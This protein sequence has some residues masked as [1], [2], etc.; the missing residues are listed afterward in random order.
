MGI[1]AA[2]IDRSDIV[3]KML[4]H[5]L[6]YFAVEVLRFDSFEESRPNLFDKK[7]DII[8]VD[9]SLKNGD[10]AV[11]YSV[12]EEMKQTPV[13]LLYRS[14]DID[15]VKAISDDE[16]PLRIKKPLNPKTVR[17]ILMELVP[18]AKESRIHPFLKFPKT[19]K[20]MEDIS[21]SYTN[22]NIE[23][24]IAVPKSS[25]VEQDKLQV[26]TH[27]PL[28]N[29]N[30]EQI[31][32]PAEQLASKQTKTTEELSKIIVVPNKPSP[33]DQNK[34]QV[35]TL[36]SPLSEKEQTQVLSKQPS[37]KETKTAEELSKI[38]V[39]PK[40]SPVDQDKL[41]VE[42]LQSPLSEKEQTQV[43][44]KQPSL[45]ETETAGEPQKSIAVPKSSPV[46]QDKLQVETLKSPLSEKEQTQALSKQPSLKE[47]KTAGEPQKSIVVPKSSSIEESSQKDSQ[48]KFKSD[49]DKTINQALIE[50]KEKTFSTILSEKHTSPRRK[51]KKEDINIDENTQ[52]DLAPL[53]IKPPASPTQGELSE[54]QS[55]ELSE[56][57]ILRVLNKYKDTLEFQELIEKILI[58]YAKKTVTHIL[59]NDKVTDLLQQPLNDF[60]ESKKFRELVEQQ[61]IQYVNRQ[62]PLLIKDIVE[63]EI[64]KILGD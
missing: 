58:E 32:T 3:Q 49:E 31:Q 29:R 53:A 2:L 62:L 13:V 55:F 15:Q 11:V 59:K 1:C 7:P 24:R 36:Q 19:E 38:I 17:D 63:Q 26:T 16:I 20:K 48:K 6:Y 57:D 12:I 4:S 52:N 61:I 33:V 28:D 8:F 47:T 10:K 56:K 18:K 44:S 45:K 41:Q 27:G 23:S 42:T 50:E 9:W 40:S 43:L 5:C 54:N 30:K 14:A 64:K 35:E 25:P 37:L 34:L 46:D 39:V 22:Q 51:V 21:E 60:K